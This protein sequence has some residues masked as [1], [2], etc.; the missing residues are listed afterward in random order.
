MKINRHGKAKILTQ[1]EIQLVFSEGFQNDR[2]RALFEVCLYSA[3]RIN[4]AST[5]NT[6]DVYDKK[7]R[8]RDEIIFQCSR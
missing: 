3:C 5:L 8:V 1:E 7:M 2:D 6:Q 4:E